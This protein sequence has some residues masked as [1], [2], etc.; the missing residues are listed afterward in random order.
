M[1]FDDGDSVDLGDN[2]EELRRQLNRLE[3]GGF[4]KYKAYLDVAQLNL[5]VR[6]LVFPKVV[7]LQ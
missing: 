6:T 3:D 4:D 5:E 2:D 7:R 1:F